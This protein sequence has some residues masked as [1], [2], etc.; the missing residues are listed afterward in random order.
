MQCVGGGLRGGVY[1]YGLF[2]SGL[3]SWLVG[4]CGCCWLAPFQPHVGRGKPGAGWGPAPPQQRP[5]SMCMCQRARQRAPGAACN[6]REGKNAIL[7]GEKM[8][9]SIGT[10]ATVAHAVA[11]KRAPP[12]RDGAAVHC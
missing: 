12:F 3:V 5:P 10:G 1:G 4:C 7:E 8:G 6:A 11:K 2:L 9:E